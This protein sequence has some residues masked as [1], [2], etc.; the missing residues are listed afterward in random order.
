[1]GARRRTRVAL[2]R[3][4]WA[5]GVAHVWE[6]PGGLWEPDVSYV[7]ATART[8]VCHTKLTSSRRVGRPHTTR[9]SRRRDVLDARSGSSD[10]TKHTSSRLLG[11][12]H[13]TRSSRRRD[14]LDARSGRARRDQTSKKVSYGS[15][16]S[17]PQPG[18]PQ[19]HR[20]HLT[21]TA[22]CA[23][24]SVTPVEWRS[25][26]QEHALGRAREREREADPPRV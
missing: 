6:F 5:P 11:R 13:T 26:W 18:A 15:K 12:P 20:G 16:C 2:P 4:L 14:V 9:S 22:A 24:G 3:D 23:G 17:T 21:T 7:V 1:M 19:P 10:H 25:A 8:S